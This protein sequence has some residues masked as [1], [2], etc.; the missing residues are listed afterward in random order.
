MAAV[1][2]GVNMKSQSHLLLGVHDRAPIGSHRGYC[3]NDFGGAHKLQPLQDLGR[4]EVLW[5][6]HAQ[7]QSKGTSMS[8][9]MGIM[10]ASVNQDR[11]YSMRCANK[12]AHSNNCASPQTQLSQ[13]FPS[14]TLSCT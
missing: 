12:D 2:Q 8:V 4:R 10:G 11:K 9:C 14:Q 5:W 3:P 7:N 13:P 6:Q 1:M